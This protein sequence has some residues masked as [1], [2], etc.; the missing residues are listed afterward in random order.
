MRGDSEYSVLLLKTDLRVSVYIYVVTAG[1]P[2]KA[3]VLQKR[4]SVKLQNQ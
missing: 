2:K 4:I 1:W 3:T